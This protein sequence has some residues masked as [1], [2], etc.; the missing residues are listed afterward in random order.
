MSSSG[1]RIHDA[2]LD[3]REIPMWRKN[4]CFELATVNEKCAQLNF[5]V[6]HE[7]G[8]TLSEME[9]YACNL[10][11]YWKVRQ[12]GC[13]CISYISHLFELTVARATFLRQEQSRSE[14]TDRIR[15]DK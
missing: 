3:Q 5:A 8:E 9:P 6:C 1:G 11:E 15:R 7:A 2:V 13:S 4:G 12:V 10:M 14:S